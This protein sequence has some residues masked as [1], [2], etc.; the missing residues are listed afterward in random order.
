MA[1]N[2][3]ASADL[4]K[5]LKQPSPASCRAEPIDFKAVG[6]PEYEGKFAVLIHDLLS[7]SECEELLKAAEST[8]DGKWEPALV[9]IGYG[10]QALLT[11]VRSCDRIIWDDFDVVDSLLQRI[12]PYL[13]ANVI[14]LKDAVH[15]HGNGP[16][17][18]KETWQMTRL[19]ERLR[20]L[21]YTPGMYFREHC[22][23]SYVTP[24]GEEISFLTVHL[25]LNGRGDL[26]GGATRFYGFD[27]REGSVYDVDPAPGACLVF[28]HR[29][30]MHSGE[31]VVKGTKF[32]VRTD[33]MYRKSAVDGEPA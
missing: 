9:N 19:N 10:R 2:A 11:D 28:Q 7:V 5:F 33:I 17:K 18:R 32:T 20:F 14:T 25:Y 21:K 23:G 26:H 6:L 15:I 24:D 29:A 3:K 1:N 27:C 22:D 30:L 12:K 31:E 13:P 8:N 16:K 4:L